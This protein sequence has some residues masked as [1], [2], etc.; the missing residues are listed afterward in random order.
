[1]NLLLV[2]FVENL[3]DVQ[4]I[5]LRVIRQEIIIKKNL[6]YRNINVDN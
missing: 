3:R 1:M 4:C 2:L 5:L 6:K